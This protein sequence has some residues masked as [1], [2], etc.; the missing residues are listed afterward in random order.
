M[1][2]K[3]TL[4]RYLAWQTLKHWN[5]AFVVPPSGGN[6]QTQAQPPEGGTLNARF[7]VFLELKQ[8]AAANF[9]HRSL[10]DLLFHK[11]IAAAAKPR[12]DA[13]RD[14]LNQH[15]HTLL[16]QGRVAIFLDGLDEISGECF[17]DLQQKITDFLYSTYSKNTVIISTRPF[18][19]R[20]LGD[21][22]MM[23]IQP[24]SPRQIEQFIL[25]ITIGYYAWAIQMN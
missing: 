17:R 24:L 15:F 11:V 12:N 23:E 4:L 20:Q 5:D 3:T 18:A 14:A 13:E 2:G 8:L 21:A 25:L 10:E 19:L 7:P 1:I 6:A 9:E 22:K 16:E